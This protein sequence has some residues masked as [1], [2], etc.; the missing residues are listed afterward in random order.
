MKNL[1]ALF[2]IAIFLAASCISAYS[3]TNISAVNRT[4]VPVN[5][6]FTFTGSGFTGT[7]AVTFFWA[8]NRDSA[9]Y[10]VMSDTEL[11]VTFGNYTQNTRDR[12]LLVESPT[13]SCLTMGGTVTE[14][15][16]TT[17]FPR[18][19]AIPRILVNSGGTLQ[20]SEPTTEVVYVK[21][22]GVLQNPPANAANSVIFAEAGATLDLRGV[23]FSTSAPPLIIYSQGTQILGALPSPVRSPLTGL[24]VNPPRQITPLSLARDI[25]PFTLGVRINVTINGGGTVT[26]DPPGPFL[27]PAT[28]YTLTANPNT[29]FVFNSW[30]GSVNGSTSVISANS[31]SID[32]NVVA[33]FTAGYTLETFSG[34]YGTISREPDLPGYLSGQVVTLTPQPAPGFQFVGWG[35]DLAG[36]TGQPAAVTMNSN[37][38][39]TAV[40]EP[41]VPQETTEI[42][43]VDYPAVP[44]GEVM[45]FSGSG[46]ADTSNVTF[47]WANRRDS[48]AFQVLSDDTLQVTFPN[49]DQNTRDRFVMIESSSGSCATM[50][51]PTIEFS[52]MGELTSTPGDSQVIVNPGAVLDGVPGWISVVYVRSGALLKSPPPSG[53]NMVILAEEGATLDLRQ[54]AF[55]PSSPPMIIYSGGTTILGNLPNPS[56]A[57]LG[58]QANFP[59]QVPPLALARDVG[60]FTLGL[61]VNL[62]SN[63]PGSVTIDPPGPF[64]RHSSSYTLTASP[65]SGAVFQ[66]W[67]GSVSGDEVV[68]TRTA[69]YSDLEIVGNFGIGYILETFSG[70]QGTVSRDPNQISYSSGDEVTL[71]AQPAPGFRFAGWGGD[72]ASSTTPSA[73][74]GMDSNKTV[75]AYFEPLI[76]SSSP[77][78]ATV[79]RTAAPIGGAF[80]FTGS[81]F[82][83]TTGVT[84]FWS[85]Y[86]DA[87]AYEVVSDSELRV[88]LPPVNQPSRNRSMM[89][90]SPQGSCLTVGAEF[91]EFSGMG[92]LPF[93]PS[94]SGVVAMPGAI[95]NG[96]H[97]GIQWVYLKSGAVLRNPPSSLP[98]CTIFAEAGAT[99]DLRESHF[100][101]TS[102]PLILYCVGTTILGD[103]PSP[104]LGVPGRAINTP[105]Q[106]TPLSL[107]TNIGPFREGFPLNLSV[108]GPGSVTVDPIM[109]FYPSGTTI[110]LNPVPNPGKYFVRWTGAVS[111]INAPLVYPISNNKGITARFS[112][113]P[114][115]F[116]DWRSRYFDTAELADPAISGIDAD[117]DGDKIS[118]S[119]EYAFGTDP[120]QSDSTGGLRILPGGRPSQDAVLRLHYNRP[121]HAADINYVIRAMTPGNAWFDGTTGDVTFDV[122][123]E[124]IV[125]KGEDLEEVTLLLR[126]T[127][128]I[129]NTMFFQISA[130]LEDLD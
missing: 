121:I 51:G 2:R 35:G 23:T 39:V 59:R 127:G 50:S 65:E 112:D 5:E 42:E 115:F 44:V 91:A 105:R 78:I 94:G 116:S 46:F 97:A 40:F 126:L 9:A 114:D 18:F 7:S 88:T 27:K 119:A 36:N 118:N 48:A 30:T 13:G 61:R 76:P 20:K 73:V 100:S 41:L 71:T 52:G 117:P 81:G 45:T 87:A 43:S 89:V 130:N 98:G 12:Y 109:D 60:P 4:A 124:G 49:V 16:G 106:I 33:N 123:E 10:Q 56:G 120:T 26:M 1:H 84:F 95:L 29:G 74:I 25:G 22:G 17:S 107:A 92:A 102:P 93:N 24:T 125:A 15:N 37:K 68:S 79:D 11:I 58:P 3:A 128:E 53:P 80:T 14:V 55:S 75:S 86:R 104:S 32:H 113:R 83:G 62:T 47:F 82:S 21:A 108:E 72:L 122:E 57:L 63:G 34:S 129:P 69:G 64:I 110:T 6:T 99:L 67:S 85:Q 31:S 77:Q 38:I 8:G 54:T 28:P 101:N 103:L 90:E 66:S 111:S 70:S 96:L 19:P